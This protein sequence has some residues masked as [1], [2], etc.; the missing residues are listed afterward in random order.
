MAILNCRLHN[1]SHKK[2]PPLVF[3]IHIRNE[4]SDTHTPGRR[5]YTGVGR[6]GLFTKREDA[7]LL[8]LAFFSFFLFFTLRRRLMITK[9]QQQQ[10]TRKKNA[11]MMAWRGMALPFS[12]FFI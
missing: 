4:Q 11:L 3:T 9:L 1:T 2:V 10:G 5:A 12:S 6:A 7:R 8:H